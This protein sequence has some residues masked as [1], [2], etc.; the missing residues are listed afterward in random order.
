MLT[1]FSKSSTG[2]NNNK[3]QTAIIADT[4]AT[5][6]VLFYVWKDRCPHI[7]SDLGGA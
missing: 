2:I 5:L 4:K 7:K 3:E 6:L 1:T